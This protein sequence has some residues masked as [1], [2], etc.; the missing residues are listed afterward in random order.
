MAKNLTFTQDEFRYLFSRIEDE[1]GKRIDVD[2]NASAFFGYGPTYDPYPLDEEVTLTSPQKESLK[3]VM[4][5]EAEVWKYL[6]DIPGWWGEYKK[7]DDKNPQKKELGRKS[8]F[9]GQQ[10][11]K[12]YDLIFNKKISDVRI[13][14]TPYANAYIIYSGICRAEDAKKGDALKKFKEEYEKYLVRLKE[15]SEEKIAG[16]DSMINSKKIQYKCY[17]YSYSDTNPHKIKS[18]VLTIDYGQKFL[19]NDLVHYHAEENDFHDYAEY[20]KSFTGTAYKKVDEVK[21]HVL[22][23]ENGDK[24][25]MILNSGKEPLKR[26]FMVGSLMGI[27]SVGECPPLSMEVIAVENNPSLLTEQNLILIH[28][29]LNLNRRSFVIASGYPDSIDDLTHR[30]K[31]VKDLDSLCGDYRLWRFDETYSEIIES[32]FQL[33]PYF[34]AVCNTLQ[35]DD[36]KYNTQIGLLKLN[37][38]DKIGNSVFITTFSSG[39]RLTTARMLSSILLRPVWHQSLPG[40][41]QNENM[42]AEGVMITRGRTQPD[43]MLKRAII[44]QKVHSPKDIVIGSHSIK[45]ILERVTADTQLK[46]ALDKLLELEFMEINNIML[47]YIEVKTELSGKFS[48]FIKE[49]DRKGFDEMTKKLLELTKGKGEESP[50]IY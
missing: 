31:M 23:E 33:D 40:K 8:K 17:Y 21:L 50:S 35:F 49:L 37:Y 44:F 42:V 20:P 10:L 36:R 15:P 16:G 30:G 13:E 3:F 12:K 38:D 43:L 32:H 1:Y 7:Q 25:D 2:T 46:S 48:D 41:A 45:K 9:N 19:R 28:R 18:F 14:D 26:D 47:R 29:Y 39:A 27:S 5:E 22:L 6:E 4:L 34:N 24:I 11:Q